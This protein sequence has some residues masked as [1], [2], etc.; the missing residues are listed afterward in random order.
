M[1]KTD[2]SIKLGWIPYTAWA[3]GDLW[4]GSREG[5]RGWEI[6]KQ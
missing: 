3:S 1:G 6:V 4:S 5:V 2:L